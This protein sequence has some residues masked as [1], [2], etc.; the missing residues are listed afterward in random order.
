MRGG[1]LHIHRIMVK[2]CDNS[3]FKFYSDNNKIFNKYLSIN[4]LVYNYHN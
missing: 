4:S 3:A 2:L 1:L